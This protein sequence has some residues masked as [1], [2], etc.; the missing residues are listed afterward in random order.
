MLIELECDELNRLVA[1]D[2]K[3][4]MKKELTLQARKEER[5]EKEMRR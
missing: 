1:D 5:I 4:L 3:E 2:L